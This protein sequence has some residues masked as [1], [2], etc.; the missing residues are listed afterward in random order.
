MSYK[1]LA[2]LLLLAWFAASCNKGNGGGT[3]VPLPGDI[4]WKQVGPD[5]IQVTALVVNPNGTM[6]ASLVNNSQMLLRSIDEGETWTAVSVPEVWQHSYI[7]AMAIDESGIIYAAFFNGMSSQLERSFDSGVT[8]TP[9]GSMGDIGTIACDGAGTVYVGTAYHD[10]STGSL[11]ISTDR[12]STWAFADVPDT[13]GVYSI[14]ISRLGTA[15]AVTGPNGVLRSTDRGISWVRSDS[16]LPANPLWALAASPNGMLYASSGY[17]PLDVY[18]STDDGASW[19][20]SGLSGYLADYLVVDAD[21]EVFALASYQSPKGLF[22]STDN[23]TTWTA[24]QERFTDDGW[25]FSFAVT[26]SGYLF[27]GARNGLQ[28]SA[29]PVT[30]HH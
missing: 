13:V 18:R 20:A 4:T 3:D 11:R 6:F 19:T 10:E 5:S 14:A 1:F 8:W 16:G 26:P 30:Q 21:N 22:R 9:S 25:V 12:G 2:V 28:R 24:I 29:L 15:C 27:V 7:K 23:G 17:S